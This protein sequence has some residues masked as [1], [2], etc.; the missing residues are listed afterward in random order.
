MKKGVTKERLSVTIDKTLL[1]KFNDF[2]NKNLINK[3]K[4]VELLIKKFMEGKR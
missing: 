3:S 1:K 2:C 4:Q